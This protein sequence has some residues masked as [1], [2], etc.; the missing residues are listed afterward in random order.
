M[1]TRGHGETDPIADNAT[2]EGRA[3]NRRAQ[4]TRVD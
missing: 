2:S 4:L 1:D 3:I